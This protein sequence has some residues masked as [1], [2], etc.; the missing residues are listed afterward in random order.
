MNEN[1]RTKAPQRPIRSWKDPRVSCFNAAEYKVKGF[2]APALAYSVQLGV[3]I[4]LREAVGSSLHKDDPRMRLSGY[5][6]LEERMQD[7]LS[8]IRTQHIV[9]EQGLASIGL[10][11]YHFPTISHFLIGTHRPV[12]V[13][14]ATIK[15]IRGALESAYSRVFNSDVWEYATGDTRRA[16]SHD[17]VDS[18]AIDAL[19]DRMTLTTLQRE[20]QPEDIPVADE[21][22]FVIDLAAP[23]SILKK[24]FLAA[25]ERMPKQ[26]VSLGVDFSDLADLG[27]LPYIDLDDW[28]QFVH[29][30]RINRAIQVELVY[31][32]DGSTRQLTQRTIPLAEK[33]LDA[34]SA[35]FSYLTSKAAE[36]LDE[37][38]EHICQQK[39]DG[40]EI[41]QTDST[42]N[43]SEPAGEKQCAL[44]EKA[45]ESLARWLPHTYPFNIPDLER[46][47][48]VFPEQAE[49]IGM[50]LE[51]ME[52]ELS[53]SISERIRKSAVGPSD[54]TAVLQTARELF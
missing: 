4:D 11:L 47:A 53:H 31:L 48:S 22:L 19:I 38:Q 17:D 49:K 24:Q 42:H 29:G 34:S 37:I 54:G 52:R 20:S 9:D 30:S 40:A 15:E 36:E 51:F 2:K 35:P 10:S 23:V 44:A 7:I 1:I 21:R 33:M 13:R 46:T 8:L 14:E 6:E 5:L 3:R 28:Q 32:H 43:K 27:V 12:F 50:I 18:D 25:I 16:V 39:D 45:E 41:D 26:K